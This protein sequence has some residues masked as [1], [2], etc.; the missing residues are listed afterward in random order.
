[1]GIPFTKYCKAS[2]NQLMHSISTME[3]STRFERL[4]R[5]QTAY[6]YLHRVA[7]SV[8]GVRSV[9]DIL[10]GDTICIMGNPKFTNLV[11]T[12]LCVSCLL[13]RRHGG[14]GIYNSS[15][16]VFI[17]DAGNCTD[18]YQYIT[19]MKQCG[20]DIKIALQRIVLSRLF[21][22]YQLVNSIL[23][24]LPKI[25]QEFN[26]KIVVIS[27]LLH[28][29]VNNPQL[30]TNEVETLLKEIGNSLYKI[31]KR[32][33]ILL[34]TSLCSTNNNNDQLHDLSSNFLHLFNK[35]IEIVENKTNDRLKL[36]ILDKHSIPFQDLVI[37]KQVGL[38]IEDLLAVPIQSEN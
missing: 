23:Y 37:R 36:R 21:T 25:I 7:F 38:S 14:L 2:Y 11:L 12:R 35:G 15:S 16:S 5:L 1:M 34:L 28:M 17:L 32:S 19:F 33:N 29:F 24:E 4:P 9:L 6:E 26:A 18:V 3:N 13:P 8:K 10:A 20:L 30:H 31:T 22:I 27:D